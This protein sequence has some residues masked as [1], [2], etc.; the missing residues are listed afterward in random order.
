MKILQSKFFVY[1][2][3]FIFLLK[4]NTFITSNNKLKEKESANLK[5]N[6]IQISTTQIKIPE[7]ISIN[8]IPILLKVKRKIKNNKIISEGM[9]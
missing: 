3:M 6:P 9:L 4:S 7:K 2:I 5:Q 8:T 1:Q